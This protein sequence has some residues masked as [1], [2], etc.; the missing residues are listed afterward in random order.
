MGKSLARAGQHWSMLV[1]RPGKL[2]WSRNSRW[3]TRMV[4]SLQSNQQPRVRGG[5]PWTR[6]SSGRRSFAQLWSERCAQGLQTLPQASL[7]AAR[8][9]LRSTNRIVVRFLTVD[10]WFIMEWRPHT[11]ERQ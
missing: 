10:A 8:R 5:R 3:A 7:A 6:A 1:L 11:E 4:R 2:W 9:A